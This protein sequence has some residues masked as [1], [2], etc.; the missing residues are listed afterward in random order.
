MNEERKQKEAV[1]DCHGDQNKASHVKRTGTHKFTVSCC[2]S[3]SACKKKPKEKDPRKQEHYMNY[4]QQTCC[5][6]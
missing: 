6:I 1:N 2:C 5:F 3:D 4:K